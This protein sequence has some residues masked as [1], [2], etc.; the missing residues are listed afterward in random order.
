MQY[1]VLAHANPGLYLEHELGS[2][3]ASFYPWTP[4]PTA[5]SDSELYWYLLP[6]PPR[7][8]PLCLTHA[9]PALSVTVSI[10]EMVSRSRKQDPTGAEQLYMRAGGIQIPDADLVSLMQRS[11]Y[12]RQTS[13]SFSCILGRLFATIFS[14]LMSPPPHACMPRAAAHAASNRQTPLAQGRQD[15]H[16]APSCQRFIGGG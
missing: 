3:A 7:Q 12:M 2:S 1:A 15:G 9:P 5:T 13:Y 14:F 4:H 16:R 10:P 6:A 11:D 8:F